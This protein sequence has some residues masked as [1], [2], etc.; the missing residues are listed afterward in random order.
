MVCCYI[1][2]TYL[3]SM[4]IKT[5]RN[6]LIFVLVHTARLLFKKIAPL[7][8]I[9]IYCYILSKN[10]WLLLQNQNMLISETFKNAHQQNI[11]KF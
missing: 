10:K 11:E 3:L 6:S 4:E 2:N 5:N 1:R 8:T 9:H 7:S